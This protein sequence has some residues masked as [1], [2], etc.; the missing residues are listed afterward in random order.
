MSENKW[1][2]TFPESF[3]KVMNKLNNVQLLA[4]ALAMS[5]AYK[6]AVPD[7]NCKAVANALE[8]YA[9]TTK[10][11][12]NVTLP[13]SSILGLTDIINAMNT[14]KMSSVA[15]SILPL[16]D[17]S[18][19]A[20][21]VDPVGIKSA[22]SGIDWSWLSEVHLEDYTEDTDVPATPKEDGLN[23]KIQAEIAADIAE[24][25]A[26]PETMHI[27][28][29]K[30]FMEWVKESP[31]HALAFLTALLMFI[32]T[33]S[34]VVS[35]W[36]ARPVKDSQVYQEPISSS[37]VVYNLTIENTVTVIG[38]IPYYYEVEFVNSETGESMIGYIYKGNLAAED[39]G[40]QEK[41]EPEA[42][43]VPETIPDTAEALS[44]SA[45]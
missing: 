16:I 6:T 5:Q 21:L 2:V 40:I 7:Y 3:L 12:S 17:T 31:E 23:P 14:V 42:T 37:K 39:S 22:L 1:N 28:S 38:D 13:T 20:S 10:S 29:K 4:S 15:A 8:Q 24:V 11:L 25:I 34:M 19:Y 44:E 33:I 41:K 35:A 30:K 43:E 9:R 45:E 18:A 26:E 32:Q 36:Q 27:T